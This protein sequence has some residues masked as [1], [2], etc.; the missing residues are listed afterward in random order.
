MKTVKFSFLL[1]LFPILFLN[2]CNN[3]DK[4]VTN[5]DPMVNDTAGQNDEAAYKDDE[6]AY[7]AM[8]SSFTVTKDQLS[9]NAQNEITG[10]SDF[11]DSYRNLTKSEIDEM[12]PVPGYSEA[13]SYNEDDILYLTSNSTASGVDAETAFDMTPEVKSAI[14]SRGFAVDGGQI[15]NNPLSI[16]KKVF[17][18]DLP[19]LVTTDAVLH[20]WHKSYADMLE[21]IDNGLSYK[22]EDGLNE[23]RSA[24][25]DEFSSDEEYLAYLDIDLLISTASALLN[26]SSGTYA[27]LSE[28]I[29]KIDSFISKCTNAEDTDDVYAFGQ[30]RKNFDFTNFKPRGYYTNSER[31]SN[32]FRA[33]T[34]LSSMDIRVYDSVRQFRMAQT[35]SKMLSANET[36]Y[37]NIHAINTVLN[38]LVGPVD[39]MT[40]FEMITFSEE[41]SISS[42]IDMSDDDILALQKTLL[43]EGYGQ[44]QI[45]SQYLETNPFS[46]K[47]EEY[48]MS[49]VFLGK[50]YTVDSEVFSNV[51]Y[52]R[53]IYN[54][55]K[56][57]RML[58]S[59]FDAMFALG[60]N[61]SLELLSEELD[62]FNYAGNLAAMRKIIE[63]KDDDFWSESQYHATL[64]N[65]EKLRSTSESAPQ[66]FRQKTWAKKMLAAQ[67]GYW[68]QLRHDNILYVKQ[69]SSGG[70]LC[71]YPD[72]YVEPY[73]EFYTGM[74]NLCSLLKDIFDENEISDLNTS[75]LDN[76]SSLC[77]TLA[78]I[79]E[80]ELAGETLSETETSFLQSWFKEEPISNC[81]PTT[82]YTGKYFQMYYSI[83]KYMYSYSAGNDYYYDYMGENP[84]FFDLEPEIADVHTCPESNLS[85]LEILSVATGGALPIFAAVENPLG[86]VVLYTG[87]V[88]DYYEF[89]DGKRYS[90]EEW[91]SLF[92][93]GTVPDKPSWMN[94]SEG[95]YITY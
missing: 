75:F 67:L 48:P 9:E 70:Y 47:T 11:I 60:D 26:P 40:P 56:V 4:T 66:V 83:Q 82:R 71:E 49:F 94:D 64:K 18:N 28:N 84:P 87:A 57:A 50:R 17:Q 65:L 91:E 55:K 95:G 68:S 78:S 85:P 3:S 15:H 20:A 12:Y 36:A 62:T 13:P 27:V 80:K 73:P 69:S 38:S 43:T 35:L 22:L 79:S 77:L 44:Q 33:F 52:D 93:S 89:S 63:T 30:I 58:P 53:I 10:F 24:I 54:D 34:W 2:G 46:D 59:S 61:L 32:Y 76:F 72:G 23:L 6:S 25:P 81:V 1:V 14:L 31:L 88:Y 29:N 7:S 16:Y 19:V 92:E 39:A 37:S 41:H 5:P 45:I 74:A 8:N 21:D 90:D 51:V 86:D 42:S